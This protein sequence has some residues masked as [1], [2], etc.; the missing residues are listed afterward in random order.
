MH[1]VVHEFNRP[2]TTA[3]HAGWN[4]KDKVGIEV[5]IY[6]NAQES[7]TNALRHGG[8]TAVDIHVSYDPEEVVLEVSSNGSKPELPLQ[9]GIGLR[10]MEERTKMI[11]GRVE[12]TAEPRFTVRTAI[13]AAKNASRSSS[14]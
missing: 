11:G 10:G 6:Q 12:W 7:I 3:Y 8:A 5:V 1:A 4:H 14:R 2:V 13:P 9:R